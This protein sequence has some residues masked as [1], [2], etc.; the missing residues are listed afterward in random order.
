M[1]KFIIRT[2]MTWKPT[3][4]SLKFLQTGLLVNWAFFGLAIIVSSFLIAGSILPK[5]LAWKTVVVGTDSM[6]PEISYGSLAIARP[7][8]QYQVGESIAFHHQYGQ[9]EK[10]VSLQQVLAVDD[11][12]DG[13]SYQVRPTAHPEYEPWQV[14]EDT[15]VGRVIFSVPQLGLVFQWLRSSTGV[16]LTIILPFVLIFSHFLPKLVQTLRAAFVA[17]TSQIL[18]F[19][20]STRQRMNPALV[21][22]STKTSS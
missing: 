19:L 10:V 5:T 13:R 12:P 16:W 8:N 11:L 2:I 22:S 18:E 21:P 6:E 1:K 17:K 20:R 4:F 9:G 7:A 3:N 14:T 15:V